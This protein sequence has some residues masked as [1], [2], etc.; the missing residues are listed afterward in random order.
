MSIIVSDDEK[1]S[2]LSKEKFGSGGSSCISLAAEFRSLECLQYLLEIYMEAKSMNSGLYKGPYSI[3]SATKWETKTV[4]HMLATK[5]FD[6]EI[7]DVLF[8]EDSVVQLIN[9]PDTNGDTPLLVSTKQR[10]FYM[11]E[12]LIKRGAI[13]EAFNYDNQT[14]ISICFENND[15]QLFRCFLE[16]G[17]FS[18]LICL[19]ISIFSVSFLRLF[20]ATVKTRR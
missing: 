8:T 11:S 14:P 12:Y 19:H 9:Y 3:F 2:V 10:N 5:P 13:I 15:L 6:V 1:I 20:K 4:L 17:R 16:N 18:V 7:L